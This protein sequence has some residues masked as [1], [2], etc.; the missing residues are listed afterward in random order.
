MSVL[1]R[2]RPALPAPRAAE[3]PDAESVRTAIRGTTRRTVVRTGAW[4]VPVVAAA[5]AAPAFAASATIC[6]AC[7]GALPVRC[8]V[9]VVVGD[10][11][12]GPCNCATGLVCATIGPLNLANVCVGSGLLSTQCGTT[13]CTGICVAAGGSLIVAVNALVATLTTALALLNVGNCSAGV[14]GFIPGNICVVPVTN[15]NAGTFGA[16]CITNTGQGLIAGTAN[17][18]V[19]TL[20]ATVNALGI[21]GLVFADQCASPYSCK[22][23]VRALAQN[24]NGNGACA[25]GNR[26]DLVVGFCQC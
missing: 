21:A 18:A 23:G 13:T 7:N 22:P 17:T 8:T 14:T 9:N 4:S 15:V 12:T 26:L 16:L 25:S 2:P 1:T 5:V 20:K 6:S 19:N 10:P 24:S 3:T 11:V